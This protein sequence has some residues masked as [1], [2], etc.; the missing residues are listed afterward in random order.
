MMILWK[1]FVFFLTLL[2]AFSVEIQS[3][4]RKIYKTTKSD[5]EEWKTDQFLYIQ[6]Y[7]SRERKEVDIN[8]LKHI[9]FFIADNEV[10]CL[11]SLINRAFVITT[12]KCIKARG[13]FFIVTSVSVT[14]M[15]AAA[16]QI[17]DDWQGM[18]LQEDPN[19]DVYNLGKCFLGTLVPNETLA[20]PQFEKEPNYTIPYDLVVYQDWGCQNSVVER[21]W[22]G[23]MDKCISLMPI[24]LLDKIRCETISNNNK[25]NLSD[26]LCFRYYSFDSDVDAFGGPIIHDEYILALHSGIFL[27]SDMQ[28]GNILH[29]SRKFLGYKSR[30][31]K[32]RN[33]ITQEE[34]VKQKVQ[35]KIQL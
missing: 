9:V 17:H 24:T 14:E 18:E 5:E 16:C 23:M 20:D 11:G 22:I 6:K 13:T 25:K 15:V 7:N 21:N 35:K 1:N 28:I 31:S 30:T 2:M 34:P 3:L 32:T 4:R 19:L 26:L 10:F 8:T 12:A 29:H 33:T 27:D